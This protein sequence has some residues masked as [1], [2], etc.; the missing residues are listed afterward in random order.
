MTAPGILQMLLYGVLLLALPAPLGAYI[1]RVFEG[2]PTPLSPV[3][4]PVEAGLFRIAGVDPARE[5][6][7]TGYALALL[8]FNLAGLL[9]VYGSCASRTCWR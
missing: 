9:A 6:H 5:Q 8:A 2:R 3:L 4:R 1:A 7:W